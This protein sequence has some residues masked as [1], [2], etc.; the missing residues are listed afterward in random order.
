M[1]VARGVRRCG[2]I[3]VCTRR[4]SGR[5]DP[6]T[7]RLLNGTGSLTTGLRARM[8][9]I[10]VN[11]GITGLTSRLTGCNTSGIVIVSGPI[12]RA[13]EARPC[14]RTLTTTVGRCGPRVVL[15]NTATVNHSLNP[16][17][18]TEINAN[19]ATSYAILRVN[20]FPLGP[21]PGG[22]RGRGRLLVA[23]P[24][25]NNGAVTAVTYPSGHPRVTAIH[26]NIVRGVTPI[27]GT[28]T[29]IVRFGPRLRRGGYCIRVLRIIGS[30]RAIISVRRT[31]VLISNNHNINDG[32]GFGLLRRLT[33]TLN[34]AISYSETI[35]SGN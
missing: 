28:G 19:L 13:C 11:C 29:R 3:F 23:H 22:R 16:H 8:A 34:N 4:I 7:F 32:R 5:V 24:T 18:S 25:F 30:I 17:I 20:S 1:V 10:L 12:L 35:I 27:R 2:N 26:P 14:A 9:T 15:I 6:V 33:R 21:L 31:G